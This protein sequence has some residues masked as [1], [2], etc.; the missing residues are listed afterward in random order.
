MGSETNR[1]CLT[2][3]KG[4]WGHA[5]LHCIG[6]G[7]EYVN[8]QHKPNSSPPEDY[9]AYQ[10]E[11]QTNAACCGTCKPTEDTV[12]PD[13]DAMRNFGTGATRHTDAGKH[14]TRAGPGIRR[15]PHTQARHADAGRKAPRR[16]RKDV[17]GTGQGNAD[18]QRPGTNAGDAAHK[19]GGRT[20]AADKL[21]H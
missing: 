9:T 20:H 13:T 6:C 10:K 11:F 14:G 3:S 15:H 2:C 17:P 21:D 16:V 5:N 12:I 4:P 19:Y 8:Y 18:A 7:E 1:M